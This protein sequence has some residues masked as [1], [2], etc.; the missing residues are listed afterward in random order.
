MIDDEIKQWSQKLAHELCDDFKNLQEEEM[1]ENWIAGPF[2][3][4][5]Y[6]ILDCFNQG[7][8]EE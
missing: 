5:F 3:K 2:N 8:F 7:I 1:T 4:V 6:M